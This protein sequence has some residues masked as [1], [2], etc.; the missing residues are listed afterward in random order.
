MT[1]E[2]ALEKIHS[3]LTF[4]SRPGL[5]RIKTLLKIMGNPQDNLKFIHIAGTN[6]KGSV[7]QML[8]SVLTTQ[9]YKTGLFISPYITDFRERIQINGKM[10]SEDELIN[11]VEET[12]PLVEY[13]RK[14]DCIITEFEYVMAL[15]FYI[16]NKANCDV[17]VLETGMGGLL[18][19]TNV[20]KPPLCS[21]ITAIGLDHTEILG[22]TIEEIAMQKC[23]IIKPDSFVVTSIQEEKAMRV[24]EDTAKKKGVPLYKSE[25]FNIQVVSSDIEKTVLKY[26]NLEITLHL[27]GLHQIENAKTALTVLENLRCKGILK[28]DDTSLVKGFKKA[29]NPAR[30]EIISRNP[31]VLLDGAHNPNG[32]EALKK[33]LDFYIKGKKK[34]CILGMLRD[35]D[36]LS[37]I[38]LL[39]NTFEEVVTVPIN[40][41]R[42][43]NEIEL[44]SKCLGHFKKVTPKKEI[45][46]AFDYAYN[47]AKEKKFALIICGSLYLSGE[48]RPYALQKTK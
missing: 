21:V 48:I 27:T 25:D 16:H 13:L 34:I 39:E 43:L 41:P 18:D 19:C 32:I 8:S 3:L 28:I 44:Y 10:I 12:F 47:K 45:F 38:K 9:G 37:S 15:E 1:Y 11:A 31:L 24:I 36:S 17:V 7:C 33:S 26:N 2:N 5:D 6:G 46:S 4:G 42:S 22:S 40:N 30:L 20:I 29:V 35:K 23:G 14:K